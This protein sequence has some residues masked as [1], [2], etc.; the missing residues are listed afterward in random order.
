[1]VEKPEQWLPLGSRGQGLTERG[2]ERTYW[3][4]MMFYVLMKVKMKAK[5]PQLCPTLFDP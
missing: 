5:F 3:I 2:Q 1:M 4:T